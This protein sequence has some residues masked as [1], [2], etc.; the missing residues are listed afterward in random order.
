M[1]YSFVCKKRLQLIS[2]VGYSGFC[3]AESLLQ[4]TQHHLTSDESARRERRRRLSPD[5]R[6]AHGA[7]AEP[8][9]LAAFS[10]QRSELCSL[11]QRKKKLLTHIGNLRK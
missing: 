5:H 8:A 4:Q 7:V 2:Q 6:F 10:P 1:S 3:D 9:Q 11:Q